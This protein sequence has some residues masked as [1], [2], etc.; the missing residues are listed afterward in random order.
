M[1]PLQKPPNSPFWLARFTSPE[2]RCA[3]RSATVTDWRAA[4]GIT[5]EPDDNAAIGQE[6][7]VQYV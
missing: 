3:Q 7:K 5:H 2:E 1:A 4:G 6:L